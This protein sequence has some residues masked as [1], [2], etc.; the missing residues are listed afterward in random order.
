MES[1][2]SPA[3]SESSLLQSV[4]RHPIIT[5]L[6]VVCTVA[7]VLW[8]VFWLDPQWSLLQRVVAGAVAGS[9]CALMIA[10]PRMVGP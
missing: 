1:Q 8:G 4:R 9:G 3:S 2:P 6:W 7:G 5:T 10:A